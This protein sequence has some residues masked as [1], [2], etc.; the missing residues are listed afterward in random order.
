M[1]S[2]GRIV[3]FNSGRHIFSA[4]AAEVSLPGTATTPSARRSAVAASRVTTM[5]PY[6]SPMDAPDDSS[7]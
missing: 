4:S 2:K 5:G 1:A 6:P 3:V 7:A